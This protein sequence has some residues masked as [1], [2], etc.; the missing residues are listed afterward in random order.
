VQKLNEVPV[1]RSSNTRDPHR[2]AV[3]LA[4]LVRCA[5]RA[6]E[7]LNASGDPNASQLLDLLDTTDARSALGWETGSAPDAAATA[8]SHRREVHDG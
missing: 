1:L 3:A 7:V 8:S 4:D 2:I 5:E 6:A